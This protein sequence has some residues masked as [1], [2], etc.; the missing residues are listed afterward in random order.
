M[1]GTVAVLTASTFV[2]MQV[3]ASNVTTRPPF[4]TIS[5]CLGH[6]G[7]PETWVAMLV[8]RGLTRLLLWFWASEIYRQ[9]QQGIPQ[10]AQALYGWACF[11]VGHADPVSTTALATL[12]ILGPYH[13]PN[14]HAALAAV[15][16]VGSLVII[17]CSTYLQ[18]IVDSDN[19]TRPGGAKMTY[20]CHI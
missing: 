15:V 12:L 13:H 3:D 11:F 9:Q 20:I 7:S 8:A 19:I 10:P 16:M 2:K 14:P 1:V 6:W 4:P 18:A 5:A 17:A